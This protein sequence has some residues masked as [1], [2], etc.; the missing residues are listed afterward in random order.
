[1]PIMLAI[2]RSCEFNRTTF[3]RVPE[4]VVGERETG[5]AGGAERREVGAEAAESADSSC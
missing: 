2:S 4:L 5:A 1:M 3:G